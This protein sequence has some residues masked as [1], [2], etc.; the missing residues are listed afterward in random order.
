M[1]CTSSQHAC[2]EVRRSGLECLSRCVSGYY[3]LM[4]EYLAPALWPIALQAIA[5]QQVGN[6]PAFLTIHS[7]R[8]T[9]PR[10]SGPLLFRP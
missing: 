6:Q 10:L 2:V 8:N 7:W 1:I 3:P 4:E 9:W 5:S